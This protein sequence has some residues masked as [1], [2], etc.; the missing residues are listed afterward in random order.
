MYNVELTFSDGSTETCPIG[1]KYDF[2][3]DEKLTIADVLL[4][5]QSILDGKPLDG[6]VNGDGSV[7]LADVLALLKQISQ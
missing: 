4:L 2:N 7:S 3:G 5:L 6:D 1:S